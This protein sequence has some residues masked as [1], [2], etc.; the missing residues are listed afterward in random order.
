MSTRSAVALPA[1]PARPH[2]REPGV[3]NDDT[4]LH[5]RVLRAMAGLYRPALQLTEQRTL[6]GLN[7]RGGASAL[8]VRRVST[9]P[10]R[11]LTPPT[12]RG[13]CVRHPRLSQA[14][15]AS[16]GHPAVGAQRAA[17]LQRLGSA[18]R[19]LSALIG[20]AERRRD[21]ASLCGRGCGAQAAGEAQC[22]ARLCSSRWTAVCA[23]SEK[24]DDRTLLYFCMTVHW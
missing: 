17:H 24:N 22:V 11:S 12:S 3:H 7:L 23:R 15:V 6:R 8:Q 2:S 14:A 13:A 19:R 18:A 16:D 20:A 4:S 9:Q 10:A 5:A 1:E 21:V